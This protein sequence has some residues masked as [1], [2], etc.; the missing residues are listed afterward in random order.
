M[1]K[2]P[3]PTNVISAD[4]EGVCLPLEGKVA[5]LG[6]TDEVSC[7]LYKGCDFAVLASG[8]IL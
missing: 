3:S 2:T 4:G 8:Y 7:S 6:Q 5:A 1:S